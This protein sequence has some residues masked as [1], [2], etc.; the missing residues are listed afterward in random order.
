MLLLNQVGKT[1]PNGVRALERFSAEIRQGEIV[2][3]ILAFAVLGKAS[4]ALLAAAAAPFLRWQDAYGA[5][6]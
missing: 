2:A 5:R 4:D 1:Y 3:A 6:S